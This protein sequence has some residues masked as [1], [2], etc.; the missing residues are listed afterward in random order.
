MDAEAF[1]FNH[2]FQAVG[3]YIACVAF[4]WGASLILA[5]AMTEYFRRG[6]A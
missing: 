2:P 5:W 1:I 3:L 6:G 4:L